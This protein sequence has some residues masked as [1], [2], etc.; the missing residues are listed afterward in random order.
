ML[1]EHFKEQMEEIIQH[2]PKSR[3]T[4]LFSATMT[5]KV[6]GGRGGREEGKERGR[7]RRKEGG[8]EGGKREGGR[9]GRREGG[10]EGL[11]GGK[12]CFHNVHV[13]VHVLN[14]PICP[15]HVLHYVHH[16]MYTLDLPMVVAIPF[17]L[18]TLFRSRS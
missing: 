12:P 1:D 3:Q 15:P 9:E 13:Y 18:H 4:M 14:A 11:L 7:E 16:L 10:R 2:C 5:D 17:C 6:R 8:S